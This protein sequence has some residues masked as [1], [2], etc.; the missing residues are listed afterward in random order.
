[1]G[2]SGNLNELWHRQLEIHPNCLI[3]LPNTTTQKNRNA[4]SVIKKKTQSH[5]PVDN[6]LH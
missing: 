3:A 2:L 5:M 4:K 6:E 1:V